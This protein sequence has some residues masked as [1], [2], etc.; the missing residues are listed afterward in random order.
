MKE[1]SDTD[2]E[3]NNKKRSD[4]SKASSFFRKLDFTQ[5][6]ELES[7]HEDAKKEDK[8]EQDPHAF[9]L[10]SDIIGP[11]RVKNI[12]SGKSVVLTI[13]GLII[14]ILFIILG[15]VLIIGSAERVADNVVFGEKEVFSVFLI[16]IGVLIIAVSLAYRFLG[17][18][19]FKEIDGHDNS[20]D[21]KSPRSS[22]NNIK[23]DNINRENR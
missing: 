8:E 5:I 15:A 4:R 20:Y 6:S 11:E 21:E 13:I 22:K 16:L 10:L 3:K 9:P 18:S 12:Q 19:F 7:S 23:K 1:D 2:P 14:G 17:K